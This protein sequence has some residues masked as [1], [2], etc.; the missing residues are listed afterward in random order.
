IRRSMTRRA[1]SSLTKSSSVER[2]IA[3][4]AYGSSAPNSLPKRS[5]V[6]ALSSSHHH[7]DVAGV[8]RPAGPHAD[9][10]P[11]PPPPCPELPFPP[12]PSRSLEL[13][14]HLLRL[15]P[16]RRVAGLP[17]AARVHG[18]AAD[19]TRKRRGQRTA[20][21]PAGRSA[22]GTDGVARLLLHHDLIRFT[23][24]VHHAHA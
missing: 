17:R 11:P 12:P 15:D 21:R 20:S 6:T 9:P 14:F 19:L 10:R 4:R 16:E 7:Q 18:N 22:A 8:H 24:H 23:A 13:V 5:G 2:T 3:P 1:R